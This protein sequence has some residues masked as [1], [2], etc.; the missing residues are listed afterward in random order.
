MST[1]TATP[2]APAQT[3]LQIVETRLKGIVTTIINE[4]EVLIEDAIQ[5]LEDVASLAPQASTWIEEAATF[6]EGIP[7]VGQ[8]PTVLATI[9]AVDLADKGLDAF[10]ATLNQAQ[11]AGA[12]VTV[13]QAKQAI[14]AGVQAYNAAKAVSA[15]IVT[16]AVIA[17]PATAAVIASTPAAVPAAS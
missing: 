9:A 4:G 13:T 1:T 16:A 7:I 17:A 15:N 5:G 6:I 11:T 3:E 12:S 8:N 14:V 10:A 2:V